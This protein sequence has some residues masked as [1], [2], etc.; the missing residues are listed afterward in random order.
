M[1]LTFIEWFIAKLKKKEFIS[2]LSLLS[3]TIQGGSIKERSDGLVSLC[4]WLHLSYDFDLAY[5]IITK[6]SDWDSMN[7]NNKWILKEIRLSSEEYKYQTWFIPE[8]KVYKINS[9]VC[10]LVEW[11]WL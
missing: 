1:A 10:G 9:E 8:V 11:P 6:Y 5:M 2:I 7:K 4:L 3:T